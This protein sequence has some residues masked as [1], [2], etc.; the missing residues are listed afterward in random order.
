MDDCTN[1]V[2]WG[3]YADGHKGVC[4]KFRTAK[5]NG[6]SSIDLKCIT[7]WGSSGPIYGYRTFPFRKMNY[8]NQFQ[9]VDFFRS[10]GRLT[11]NQLLNQ[12]Y[13]D[14]YENVSKCG[15]HMVNKDTVE[16]WRKNYWNNYDSSFFIKLK[17][18]EYEKE[19]RLFLSSSLE[20]YDTQE[21]R[22]LKYKFEDLEAIIFGIRTPVRDKVKIIKIIETK[23]KEN[24]RNDFD[25][26]QADYSSTS[27]KM[28]I[29]KLDF[30][31]QQI[32]KQLD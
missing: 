31:K 17:E 25:F 26:Y 2:V 32:L 29:K 19:Q 20:M 10:I 13:T 28:E 22:K 21:S 16:D 30:I 18:W 7:G 6:Y 27:G 24:N 1:P 4:L 8:S 5:T 11:E 12:W 15:K 14:K 3:H 23:C 9:S